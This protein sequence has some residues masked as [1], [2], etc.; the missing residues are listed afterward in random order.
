[1]TEFKCSPHRIAVKEIAERIQK[2]SELDQQRRKE[3]HS[4]DD[5][6]SDDKKSKSKVWKNNKDDSAIIRQPVKVIERS[7]EYEQFRKPSK[8]KL[9]SGLEAKL[10]SKLLPPFPSQPLPK[11]P[12][13]YE[14]FR[15][16]PTTQK[17]VEA[18][19]HSTKSQLPSSQ[20]T[21][22]QLKSS[23]LTPLNPVNSKSLAR[24]HPTEYEQVTIPF[25]RN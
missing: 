7:S 14:Q 4:I 13:E 21:S 20:L 12:T 1:M 22:S 25:I 5:K 18:D 3:R 23:Q 24:S 11:L 6:S 8:L 9:K 17:K 2:L 19:I 15:K 10:E 16:A